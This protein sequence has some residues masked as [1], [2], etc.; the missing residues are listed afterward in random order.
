ML[1]KRVNDSDTIKNDISV[2]YKED[3]HHYYVENNNGI[4]QGFFKGN[5]KVLPISLER[6]MK[7]ERLLK[8]NETITKESIELEKF[9][10]SNANIDVQW[11]GEY[12]NLCSGEWNIKIDDMLLPIPE[13]SIGS[14]MGTP[15]EYDTWSFDENYSEVFDS[16]LSNGSFKK[17]I[18]DNEWLE[19]GI[20]CLGIAYDLDI[21]FKEKDLKR[22]YNV[23]KENDFR[24]GSCG[25]C[26]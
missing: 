16:Y 23:I 14:D 3:K 25:G 5:F 12:P 8:E 6:K 15:G 18:K 7:F 24:S 21:K 11:N 10:L 22:I 4:I 9:N 2:V 19:Y 26:I 20:E 1:V 13:N 17:W